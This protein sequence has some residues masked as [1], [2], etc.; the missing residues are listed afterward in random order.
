[1]ASNFNHFNSCTY[2]LSWERE[3]IIN[4]I[5]LQSFHFLYIQSFMRDFNH[6]NSCTYNLKRSKYI[7]NV[8]RFLKKRTWKSAYFKTLS[9]FFIFLSIG[10]FPVVDPCCGW[11]LPS[12]HINGVQKKPDPYWKKPGKL[13]HCFQISRF[14]Y[15]FLI[16]FLQG[17][18]FWKQKQ[19]R[20]IF[21]IFQKKKISYW[22]LDLKN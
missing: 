3:R 19:V 10:Y 12:C 7:A 1:M 9:M 13:G 4:G 2:I 15:P 11:K 8:F 22:Q 6:F 18:L 21:E 20:D 17:I 16:F 14:S 5:K